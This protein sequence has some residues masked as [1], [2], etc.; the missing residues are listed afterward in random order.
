MFSYI[1]KRVVSTALVCILLIIFLSLLIHIVPGDPAKT[2][3]GPRATPE[4]IEKIHTEMGLD[5]T[6]FQQITGFFLNALHG[7]LGTDVFTGRPITEMI[8]D[9]FPHSLIL[10]TASLLL[11]VLLGIPLGIF[12]A[13]HPNT[14]GDRILAFLSI[15][16]ITIPSYVVALIFLLIFSAHLRIFPVIGLGSSGNVGDYIMHLIIPALVLSL[17]WVGYLAR[18]VRTSLLE[19][20]NETYITAERSMGI[21]NR[22]LLFRLALKN[23]LIPTVAVL[24]VGLGKMLAGTVFV[25]IIFSRPGMGT[26]IMKAIQNRNY[27]VVQGVSLIIALWFVFANL[28][29]DIINTRLDPRIQIGKTER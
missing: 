6:P 27:P 12:S 16:F 14:I 1:L 19:V 22:T 21:K 4:L 24:G 15:S 7:D 29:A 17:S 26:L 18:L 9:V 13:T 3:L 11:A 5:K 10:T 8:M 2:I 23:A 25:E 28:L 20:L